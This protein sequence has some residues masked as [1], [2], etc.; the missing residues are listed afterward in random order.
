M[1]KIKLAFET[2][3]I[4]IVYILYILFIAYINIQIIYRQ[5]SAMT[6]F[7]IFSVKV[8]FYSFRY[9]GQFYI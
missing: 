8:T 1:A 2:R 3:E 6:F 4:S 5:Q 9:E 7:M